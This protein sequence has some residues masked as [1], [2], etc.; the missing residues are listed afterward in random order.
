M[1][2]D[3]DFVARVMRGDPAARRD[4]DEAQR[5]A[6]GD[7]QE[8]PNDAEVF[9]PPADPAAYRIE[10]GRNLTPDE[11]TEA[12]SVQG[13]LHEAQIPLGVGNAAIETALRD[14]NR[15]AAMSDDEMALQIAEVKN[16]LEQLWGADTNRRLGLARQLVNEI[17]ARHGGKVREFLTNTRI[18]NSGPLIVALA[19][20]AERRYGRT[21]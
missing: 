12:Q 6:Y 15:F 9:G 18:G 4:L 1:V 16:S 2:H 8:P 14:G 5:A 20:A 19:T 21:R 13:W 17:D 7:G 10:I 3:E 11:V